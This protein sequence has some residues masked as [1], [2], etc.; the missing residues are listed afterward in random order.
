MKKDIFFKNL[1]D[2]LDDMKNMSELI[3]YDKFK[4]YILEQAE[5]LSF[6]EIENLE[7]PEYIYDWIELNISKFYD[8]IT[9][10]EIFNEDIPLN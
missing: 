8:I 7:D 9:P 4:T 6:N 10:D 3:D 2:I 1:N 5:E